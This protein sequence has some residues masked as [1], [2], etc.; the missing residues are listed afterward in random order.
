MLKTFHWFSLVCGTLSLIS[1]IY[2]FRVYMRTRTFHKNGFLL[3]LAYLDLLFAALNLG[4]FV[5]GLL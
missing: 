3:F 1:A 2:A 4:F 5:Q